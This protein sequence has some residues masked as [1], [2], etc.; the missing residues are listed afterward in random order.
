M[1]TPTSNIKNRL[2]IEDLAMNAGNTALNCYGVIG[3]SSRNTFR[4]GIA[5]LLKKDNY[6]RG[7]FIKKTKSGIEVDMFIIVAMGVKI[8]EVVSQV[9]KRVYYELS[10]QF[11]VNFKSVNIYVQDVMKI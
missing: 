3:M 8:T 6:N 4:E 2:T 9:Q 7:V 1:N 5:E 11:D 10:H